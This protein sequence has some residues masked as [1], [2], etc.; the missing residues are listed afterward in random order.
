M[1]WFHL[2]TGTEKSTICC[3]GMLNVTRCTAYKKKMSTGVIFATKNLNKEA[4]CRAYNT[5]LSP[6]IA[7]TSL[8]DVLQGSSSLPKLGR[9]QRASRVWYRHKIYLLKSSFVREEWWNGFVIHKWIK[10]CP[11]PVKSTYNWSTNS[12]QA[13]RKSI[14]STLPNTA[15]ILAYVWGCVERRREEHFGDGWWTQKFNA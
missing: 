3:N 12:R 10:L 5:R 7:R 8:K 6:H 9:R 14:L 15:L 1:Y 2:L 13:L 4:M 11:K